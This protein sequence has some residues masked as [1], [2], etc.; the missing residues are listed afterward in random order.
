MSKNFADTLMT[1]W[2]KLAQPLP[3]PEDIKPCPFCGS[4]NCQVTKTGI[5]SNFVVCHNCGAYGP[6]ASGRRHAIQAW[7]TRT[8]TPSPSAPQRKGTIP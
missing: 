4:V 8:P 3:P 2:A 1:E 5:N 6:S 7:N